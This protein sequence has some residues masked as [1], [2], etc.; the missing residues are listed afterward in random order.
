MSIDKHPELEAEADYV[1]R[2]YD[3]LDRARN[4][5]RGLTENVISREGGTHQARFER[6]V[7]AERVRERIDHLDIG[8]QSLIFGRIYLETPEDPTSAD[9]TSADATSADATSEPD[10]FHIGRVGVSDDQRRQIVVDWRA[11]IAEKFYRATGRAHM[12]LSQRRHFISRLRELVGLEDEYFAGSASGKGTEIKGRASL[13]HAI[14]SGRTG[15]LGDIVAT[16]QGEQDEIIRAGLSGLLLVQG[17]PGTGKTV[18]A[19]HRAAYLLFSNRFPLEGQGV[20]VIGPNR[21]FMTYIEQVLPS[22]GESGVELAV[23][24]DFVPDCRIRGNDTE[25]LA[26]AKG[27]IAMLDVISEAVKARQRPLTQTLTVSYG[28][29]RLRISPQAC[30]ELISRTRKRCRN[31]NHGHR[32]FVQDF[33]ETLAKSARRYEIDPVELQEHLRKDPA[34]VEAIRYMWPVLSPAEFLFDFYRSEAAIEALPLE[35]NTA[36]QT[37]PVTWLGTVN[38]SLISE[39]NEPE[40]ISQADQALSEE[41]KEKIWSHQDVPLLD[42]ANQLLGP[43]SGKTS[44]AGI[45]TYGHIVIDE[46]QDLSPMQLNM[47]AKRSLNG[48]MTVV[49]D[50]AQ[51]TGAWSHQ[52]WDGVLEYLVTKK[53]VE[54]RDLTIGYRLP[55]PLM[56]YAEK[57]LSKAMPE[58]QP[59]V[60]VRQEGDP[61]KITVTSPD[62]FSSTLVRTIASEQAAIGVGNIAV[63]CQSGVGSEI[64]EILSA[65]GVE[66]GVAYSGALEK[67]VSVIE[68]SMVK[69]LEIDAAVV[70]EPD[71]IAESD[72]LRSLYVALTRA[73]RR[74][75][76][77]DTGDSATVLQ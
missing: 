6:D 7:I 44:E 2:A 24:A 62:E 3:Q 51:A 60:A 76:I 50:I 18:V 63:I 54:E 11:P 38:T 23:L 15:R 47:I 57:V 14:E 42:F 25:A 16:I 34:V 13:I 72:G 22:L 55:A 39:E 69:G 64:S 46:A 77:I 1:A 48:S 10:S 21:L 12:G 67:A 43:T 49:G 52:N 71:R 68:V 28:V 56:G 27:D 66:H 4:A 35:Q 26:Y 31:H 33:F 9:S 19:L 36:Q 8:D 40:F 70:I 45:R 53:G 17:G 29:Q 20:L 61:A 59:P 5:A 37:G 30:E 58:I 32:F 73:T 74:L 75:H 65:E 41:A